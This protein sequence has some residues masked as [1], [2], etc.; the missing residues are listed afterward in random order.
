MEFIHDKVISLE[1]TS[2]LNIENSNR[3]EDTSQTSSCTTAPTTSSGTGS[4]VSTITPLTSTPS[5][6]GRKRKADESLNFDQLTLQSS[7]T[8][9]EEV[10]NESFFKSLLPIMR[11]LPKKK[12]RLARKKIQE[13]LFELEESC[14]EDLN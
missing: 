3:E 6:T 5:A 11:A 7:V 2:N 13:F 14:D 1:T 8:E 9:E 10:P 12:N 4:V